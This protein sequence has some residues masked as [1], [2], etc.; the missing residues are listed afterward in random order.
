MTNAARTGTIRRAPGARIE[1]SSCSPSRLHDLAFSRM[2]TPAYGSERSVTVSKW[3][4]AEWSRLSSSSP[5][6]QQRRVSKE[7]SGRLVDRHLY[8]LPDH[9]AVELS[10]SQ[11][12]SRRKRE[13]TR[14]VKTR[15]LEGTNRFVI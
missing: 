12:S 10:Q 9:H 11:V 13:N 8:P 4:S 6:G 15:F 3:L 14:D 1:R 5:A 7:R 2:V